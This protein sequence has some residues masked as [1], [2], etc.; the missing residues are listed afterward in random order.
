MRLEL[1][2]QAIEDIVWIE[3]GVIIIPSVRNDP[4]A[5]GADI[6]SS[7]QEYPARAFRSAALF[8]VSRNSVFSPA[9]ERIR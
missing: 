6:S 5:I 3:Q 8:P 9:R 7:G 4:L 2:P 1:I